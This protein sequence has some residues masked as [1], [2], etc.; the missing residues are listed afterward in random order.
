MGRLE[1]KQTIHGNYTSVQERVRTK[2]QDE[3]F[4]TKKT[5][6]VISFVTFCRDILGGCVSVTV[7]N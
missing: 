2:Y 7:G 6:I 3:V 1:N 5:S 4:T